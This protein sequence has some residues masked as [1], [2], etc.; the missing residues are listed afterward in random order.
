MGQAIA[1]RTVLAIRHPA[2]LVA[3]VMAAAFGIAVLVHPATWGT[4]TALAAGDKETLRAM[5]MSFGAFAPL[6][7]ILLN[8][9]QAVVA[10]VPGF[11][12]PFVDGAVFGTWWGMLI[13]WVGGVAGASSCFWIARTFGARFAERICSQFKIAGELNRR[14][15][16]HAFGA[17][18][19]ARLIPGVPFDFL[20]YFVGLTRVRFLPF[21]AATA[22]GSAPH[23]FLYAFMGA[24][25]QIPL[26]LG[27]L[28]TPALGLLFA[29]VKYGVKLV[30]QADDAAEY[31]P[32][33]TLAAS[34]ASSTLVRAP[35]LP[36][37]VAATPLAACREA[38]SIAV[39]AW[40]VA[41][42]MAR[43]RPVLR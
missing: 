7:S 3:V 22:I 37:W 38:R 1:Q 17:I 30:R 15:E 29:I 13:T 5:I 33:T 31:A 32:A 23:A 18:I 28:M 16:Q 14:L 20:S 21:L 9:A 2:M 26:W 27:V 6:A 41:P 4:F 10:P 11:V 36:A 12:I 39:T 25:L 43:A 42:V 19:L 34:L 40:A 24:S 35:A 8:V